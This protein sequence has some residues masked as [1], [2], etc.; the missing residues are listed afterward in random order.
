MN[1]FNEFLSFVKSLFSW[2]VLI[3]PWE[4]GIRVRLGKHVRLLESGIH[5]KIPIFDIIFVQPIRTRIVPITDQSLITADKKVIVLAGSFAYKIDDLLKLYQTLHNPTNAIE[6]KVMGSVSAH[7]F[8]TNFDD[9]EPDKLAQT[10]KREIDLSE[11]GL[12]SVDF[13]LT[14]FA[15]VKTYR[16]I[17]GDLRQYANTDGELNLE[18]KNK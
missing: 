4:Q 12:I 13:F 15:S 3:A 14:S 8:K 18:N 9:L 16:I 17:T 2:Y 1:V 5:F 7:V 11:F 10:V 6:Q